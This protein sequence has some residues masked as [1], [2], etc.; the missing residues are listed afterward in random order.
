MFLIPT[1]IL[2]QAK[3]GD[4][5]G[6]L[7]SEKG[8]PLVFA[9]IQ[10][11]GNTIG[12]TTNKKGAFTLKGIPQGEQTILISYIGYETYKQFVNIIPN[13]MN[14]LGKV[15][16]TTDE[17]DMK[18][19]V[20][21][22]TRTE[23]NVEDVPIPVTVVSGE[24]IESM[25]SMRLGEVLAEQTGLAVVSD[26]GNGIQV[27]GFNSDYTLILING[28]PII[29][30]TAGTLELDRIT[31]NNI[32]QIEITKGPSSSLY[33][34][35]ALAGVINIITSDPKEAFN[36]TIR[37]KYRT[38]NTT[39]IGADVELKHKRWGS[40]FQ[41][42]R[43]S[44]NG[45][46]L[47]PE[48]IS[49][50]APEFNS[51]TLKGDLTYDISE[52]S[53]IKLSGRYFQENQNDR[54]T[55]NIN[56][57]DFILS[58]RGK[59]DDWNLTPTFTHNFGKDSKLTIVNYTTGYNTL[60]NYDFQ[61][62]RT[63]YSEGYFNQLY[64]RSEAQADIRLA[65]NNMLTA[66]GGYILETLKS[67]R[68]EGLNQFGTTYSFIQNEWT[69][70]DKKISVL[71]G[72]R[73]DAHSEYSTQLS[74]KLAAQYKITKWLKVR[75][76]FGKGF[77][78]PDFRQLFLNFT[79]PTVGYSVFGSSIVQEGIQELESQGQIQ[80]ILIDPT[81]IETIKAESSTAI[82]LG[83]DLKPHKRLV[84]KTNIFRNDIQ[85]LIE[86]APVALK[87]NGQQV[88]TYFNI[89]RVYTQGL[90]S[91]LRIKIKK[92]FTISAGY[93]YL[94]AKDKDV[95]DELRSG[96]V[97]AIDE[98]TSKTVRVQ[99][100]SYGGLFNRSKHSGTIKLFY[101]NH[102]HKFSFNIRG[103][104]RGD[105]GFG[106]LNNNSILDIESEYA[107][108]Y[109][110]WHAALSKKLLKEEQLILQLGI[111]NLF[112][113]T[114]QYTPSLPGRLFYV[115]ASW[116]IKKKQSKSTTN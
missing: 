25:G 95:E 83:F 67:D 45:Y 92:G 61:S 47:T 74:P 21:T 3:M 94:E 77:K 98:E 4:L 100:S 15:V 105:F 96:N 57:D 11:K 8:E 39:D 7:I 108:G 31:V 109:M 59:Q 26:H 13:Q 85:D 22:A 37:A 62:D 106:D 32:K 93:Q 112:E 66:G 102:Q 78:A 18:E 19:F 76:S 113:T 6:L 110:T 63:S 27:Q 44:S 72:A 65:K 50:T 1:I 29:G 10:I 86:A 2:S 28:Q 87:T 111:D 99:P 64:N 53:K 23:R 75:S 14:D 5:K 84:L 52:K 73:F 116:T 30:R 115:G 56:G 43:Y 101:T 9:S 97:F 71:A 49:K 81:T 12:T 60:S 89:S 80:G 91:E 48:T 79:N 51:Y 24:Q 114:N 58:F 90:E 104:Y 17:Q 20:V 16:L 35:E 103:V 107:K 41:V 36:A 68:Y 88:F 82:N 54:T 69:P 70:F 55:A 40:Y 34:S 46:D 38:Y 42:N 33:G